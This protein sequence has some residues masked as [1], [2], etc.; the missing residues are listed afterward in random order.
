ML[1]TFLC[2]GV[3]GAK[4]SGLTKPRLW[5]VFFVA[6]A[7][8][9]LYTSIGSGSRGG[10]IALPVI[11][12]VFIAAYIT[13]RNAKYVIA[14]VLALIVAALAAVATVPAIEARYNQAASDRSEEHTSELQSLMRISY[15]VFCLKKKKYKTNIN[16]K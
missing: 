5:R 10:W 11:V 4:L 16:H 2:S 12:A 1:G 9:G 14:T 3:I 7:L 13:Q 6:G 15:A 8:A